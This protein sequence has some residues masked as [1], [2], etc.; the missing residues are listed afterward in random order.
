LPINPPLASH[1]HNLISGIRV[2][3]LAGDGV[4]GGRISEIASNLIGKPRG[5]NA[6]RLKAK[7]S[8]LNTEADF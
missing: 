6:E 3:G 8:R 2:N 7:K 1:S 4:G 5:L